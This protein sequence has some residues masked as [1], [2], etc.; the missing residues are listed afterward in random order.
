MKILYFTDPHN[1]D[2]P[3]LMRTSTYCEDILEKQEQL[4][5]PAKKCDLVIC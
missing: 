5:E 4:V 2:T 1:S 3:P